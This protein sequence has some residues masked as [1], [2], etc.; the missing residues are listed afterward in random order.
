MADCTGLIVSGIALNCDDINAAVGVGKDLILV[1]YSDFDRALTLAAGNI[2]ADDT[3]GNIEGLTTIFLK[4]GATQYVFE[5]TDYS[6]QPNVASETKEDGNSWYIHSIL[7]TSY[8][9]DSSARNVIEDLGQSNVVAIAVDRSTG[10]YELF[11]A[12]QGLKLSALERA[13]V[14][15][16]TSNFYQVT[17]ATP[18]IAV[19]RESSV[20]LLSVGITTAA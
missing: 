20:G 5:G 9:K 10:L 3:N 1:N 8:N 14:G 15:T 13:Y 2:E 4:T 12:D 17:L 6:V 19:V 11:G 7:F 18:D 16:Q